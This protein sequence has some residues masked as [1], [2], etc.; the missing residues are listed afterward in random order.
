MMISGSKV[1][2]LEQVRVVD[3]HG[4][5]YC[6]VWYHHRDDGVSRSAR[7]GKEDIYADAQPGDIVSVF[8]L[9]QVVTSVQPYHKTTGGQQ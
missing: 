7:I 9:M 2:V 1:A 8:Y 6:D 3:I 4:T 5:Q